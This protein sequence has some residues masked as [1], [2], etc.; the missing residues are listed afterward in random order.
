M[1]ATS[2]LAVAVVAFNAA[3]ALAVPM[4]PVGE[5]LARRGPTGTGSAHAKDTGVSDHTKAGS[6]AK[7][8]ANPAATT[9]TI[10]VNPRPT[11]CNG[12]KGSHKGSHKAAGQKHAHGA[13][14]SG[15]HTS[16]TPGVVARSAAA[17]ATPSG[18]GTTSHTAPTPAPQHHHKNGAHHAAGEVYSSKTHVGK[19]H[20][21]TV[22]MFVKGTATHCAEPT[23]GANGHA[24]DASHKGAHQGEKGAGSSDASGPTKGQKSSGKVVARSAASPAATP[25][26]KATSKADHAGGAHAHAK[27][28]HEKGAAN[29]AATTVTVTVK[30]RPTHCNGHKGSHKKAGAHGTHTSGQ[31]TSSTPGVVARS[32]A[33]SA[34]PSG[35]GASSN[36]APTPAPEHHHNG[37][38][39][40]GAAS[41][42]HVFASATYA[43]KDHKTAVRHFVKGTATQH[44]IEPTSGAGTHAKGSSH[45]GAHQGEKTTTDSAAAHKSNAGSQ[46]GSKTGAKPD[47]KLVA[48]AADI[49]ERFFGELDELD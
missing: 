3:S 16:S 49:L 19:D 18:S 29:P 30:P 13:H 37:G 42:G 2:A 20:K 15:H 21:T 31:H 25:T 38:H 26:D 44:C 46:E 24:K 40:K 6:H 7:G 8:A 23:L 34:T 45:K 10:T 48:R 39:H 4:G 43:G 36:P 27:G 33:A 5:G 47:P 14:T 35:S 28:A 22:H 1:H 12:H 17:S 11:D 41:P 32:A 9:V